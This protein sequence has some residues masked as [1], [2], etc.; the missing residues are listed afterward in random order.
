MDLNALM[1]LANNTQMRQLV[2][3]LINQRG[4]QAGTG[5]N[6]AGLIQN[7]DRAGLHDQVTS[8]IGTGDNTPISS[9]QLTQAIGSDHL[10][11]A[12][13]AAGMSDKQAADSLAK[14][15]PQVVDQASPSGQVPEAADFE[16]LFGRLFG[17]GGATRK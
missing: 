12:A 9:K 14:V 15:L 8:W 7:L 4:G 5:Q 11:E 2:M 1:K 3:S 6:M 16:Q 10:H 13:E 17:E